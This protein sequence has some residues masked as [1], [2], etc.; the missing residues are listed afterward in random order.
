MSALARPIFAAGLLLVAGC[1]AT[2]STGVS[3]LDEVLLR[4]DDTP[5]KQGYLYVAMVESEVAA[6][7]AGLARAVG[8][9]SG[10]IKSALGEVVY[11]LDPDRAPAWRAKSAGL[12]SG[13]AGRG[14]GVRRASERAAEAL[15]A[16]ADSGSASASLREA[17]PR[18]AR[19]LD[20][21]EQRAVRLLALS[22]QALDAPSVTQLSEL[23]P[24]IESLARELNDGATG[25]TG[26]AAAEGCGLRQAARD[27]RTVVPPQRS[28]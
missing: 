1:T 16:A 11:A 13:W 15:E 17:A 24:G 25:A 28:V 19:C 22:E 9:D 26:S 20:N 5:G 3:D 8:D 18:A 6:Q 14:Y 27:L 2:G 12:V 10:A 21:T 7:Y 4:A 23:L